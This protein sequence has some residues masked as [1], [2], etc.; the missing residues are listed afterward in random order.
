MKRSRQPWLSPSV[1][2]RAFQSRL[3]SVDPHA[4]RVLRVE[5][6]RLG[7]FEDKSFT[8]RYR[9]TLK[10]RSGR[11]RRLVLRGSSEEKDQTRRQAYVIMRYLWLHGFAEGPAQ[12]ARPGRTSILDPARARSRA[13]WA[14]AGLAS[15]TVTPLSPGPITLTAASP[16][17]SVT[18]SFTAM[19]VSSCR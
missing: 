17:G 13:A 16:I 5:V 6:E 19:R 10:M 18:A 8:L 1:M 14:D 2:R 12:V 11:E 15:A 7:G 9:L 4:R 3:L